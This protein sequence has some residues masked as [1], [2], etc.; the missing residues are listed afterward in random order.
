VNSG[1]DPDAWLETGS[2]PP[3]KQEITPRRSAPPKKLAA[4]LIKIINKNNGLR[5]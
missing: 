2:N 1:F 4:R 3:I 5:K